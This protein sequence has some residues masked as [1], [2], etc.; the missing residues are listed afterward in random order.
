MT[1][2]SWVL[3]DESGK[4]MRMTDSFDS[5]TEAE[6]WLTANWKELDDDGVASV[7]LRNGAE[8]TYRMSLAPE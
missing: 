4:E 7:S 1:D 3:L 8:E 2:W 6:Q 5:Q